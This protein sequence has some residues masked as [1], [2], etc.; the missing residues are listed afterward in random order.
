MSLKIHLPLISATHFYFDL[1][2]DLGPKN[3]FRSLAWL[4]SWLQKMVLESFHHHSVYISV[5]Q[6]Q[7]KWGN[8]FGFGRI[9]PYCQ[10]S[11]FLPLSGKCYLVSGRALSDSLK[12]LNSRSAFQ[13]SKQVVLSL[14]QVSVA[15]KQQL[16]LVHLFVF[17]LIIAGYDFRH[18]LDDGL[19]LSTATIHR[20]QTLMVAAL[21]VRRKSLSTP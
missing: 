1:R 14:S 5:F 2:V 13:I 10:I 9:P 11:Q 15:F 8:A 16:M 17:V 6:L 18:L 12:E 4:R 3:S 20:C 21:E 19:L 7:K